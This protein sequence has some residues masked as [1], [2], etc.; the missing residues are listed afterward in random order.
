MTA[1]RPPL[2]GLP[3]P[4]AAPEPP[5][6]RTVGLV[7]GLAGP[8]L[9]W[10][11]AQLRRSTP[12]LPE[13]GV[14]SHG[15]AGLGFSR[16]RLLIVGDSSAAG[17]GV[18]DPALT[19]APMLAESLSRRIS[20][21]SMGLTRVSWQL[22]ARTGVSS[23]TAL[24]LMASQQLDQADVLVTVLGVNDVLEQTPPGRWLA[25]LDAIRSHAKHRAK[26]RFTVHCAPPRMDLMHFVPQPLRWLMG[27]QASR[28]DSALR[29]HV[30]HAYRRS[31]FVLPFD[32]TTEDVDHWLAA[33]RFHPN[34]ALYARWAEA[35]ADH[36]EYD[37]TQNPAR[38]AVLP[39][40]FTPSAWAAL[41]DDE[42][43]PGDS[44]FGALG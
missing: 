4:P 38:G 5:S 40:G 30:R 36:I 16:L 27:A 22:A 11:A 29:S 43:E 28:L 17:V 13:P 9:A 21:T 31:R 3:R 8:L 23:S 25:N 6:S 7:R 35:L 15:G 2:V 37:L 41:Q 1:T 32:P 18:T 34:A 42:A 19:L 33:D 39:T 26:V 20:E 14:P 10:Q 12:R 44:R 24:P